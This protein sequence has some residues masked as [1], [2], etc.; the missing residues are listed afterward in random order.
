MVVLLCRRSVASD[1]MSVQVFGVQDLTNKLIDN[2][3]EIILTQRFLNHYDD[4]FISCFFWNHTQ[5]CVLNV[6]GSSCTKEL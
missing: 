3:V 2:P 5:R 6:I 4:S 1:L